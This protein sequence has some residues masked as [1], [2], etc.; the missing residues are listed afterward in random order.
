MK[1]LDE[2]SRL[3][4]VL[5][6]SLT[7]YQTA[8]ARLNSVTLR[9]NQV[10]CQINSDSS[11]VAF[12]RQAITQQDKPLAK[13]VCLEETAPGQSI[14]PLVRTRNLLVRNHLAGKVKR[15]NQGR[16]PIEMFICWD[17]SNINC[18][19]ILNKDEHDTDN[20]EM[21]DNYIKTA[22]PGLDE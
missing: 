5:L 11:N 20:I 2:I 13:S 19:P 17:S 6:I 14:R 10:T 21:A 22:E 4:L 18:P 15:A 3:I 9:Q 1:R 7:P 16:Q 8:S 12:D